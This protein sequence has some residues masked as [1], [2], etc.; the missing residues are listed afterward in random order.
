MILF[1][2]GIVMFKENHVLLKD[3]SY[4]IIG[5]CM[6]VH[7]ELGCGFLEPV[8]QE[9]LEHEFKQRNIP[10]VREKSLTILYK[11]HLLDKKYQVDFICYGNIIIELK[12]LQALNSLHDAQLINYLKATN[13]QLGILVNFGQRSLESKRLLNNL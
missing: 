4:N 10:Y 11:G 6:A 9:A 12:A 5:A 8:Y 2:Q 3:E 7:R 13:M 1:L